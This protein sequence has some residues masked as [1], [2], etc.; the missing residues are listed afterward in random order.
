MT[1]IGWIQ[2]DTY[3]VKV[4]GA[5]ILQK[6]IK[7]KKKNKFLS[8]TEVFRFIF[9]PGAQQQIVNEKMDGHIKRPLLMEAFL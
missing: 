5:K 6:A 7:F 1:I 2:N 8:V 9:T 3:Q 4:S